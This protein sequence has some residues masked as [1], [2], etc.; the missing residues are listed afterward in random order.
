VPLIRDF[1][2]DLDRAWTP[3]AWPKIPLRII[4]STALMLQ[5][6]YERGTKDSD[7]LETGDLDEDV[8]AQLESI[9]GQRSKLHIRHK[10]YVDIVSGGLP[11]LAPSPRWLD[12][13]DLNADLTNFHVQVL[14]IVD[15]VVSKL[16]RFHAY[17]LQD[18]E[19]MVE[20][21]LVN[22][23]LLIERFR[24]AVDGYLL[25]ARADDLPKYVANLHRVERDLFGAPETAIE[26]P[27][28]VDDS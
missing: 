1:L 20:R 10:L 8:R 24:E 21:G 9:A 3:T 15:V 23:G 26:L 28:W 4:G 25:D 5:A 14:Q 18:I 13:P 6:S 12:I 22:H 2:R 17:D 11:F 7:V 19:A 16:K 27:S